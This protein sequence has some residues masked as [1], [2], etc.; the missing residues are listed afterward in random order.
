MTTIGAYAP[1]FKLSFDLKEK[2]LRAKAEAADDSIVTE[3]NR[4]R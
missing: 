1:A 2:L 3:E 4:I